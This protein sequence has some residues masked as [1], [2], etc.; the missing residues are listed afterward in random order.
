MFSDYLPKS[1]IWLF[2]QVELKRGLL[3]TQSSGSF[4]QQTQSKD[5]KPEGRPGLKLG[6]LTVKKNKQKVS[7]SIFFEAT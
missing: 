2:S 3:E 5:T 7:F 1:P 4:K 6:V